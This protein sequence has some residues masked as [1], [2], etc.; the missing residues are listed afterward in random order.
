M[1][2]SGLL[3]VNVAGFVLVALVPFL[4][5]SPHARPG[6]RR[7]AI[8]LAVIILLVAVGLATLAWLTAGTE[9]IGFVFR[10]AA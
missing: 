3:W 7:T 8:V 10:A 1:G 2:V 6:Q 5:R 4:D 9:H